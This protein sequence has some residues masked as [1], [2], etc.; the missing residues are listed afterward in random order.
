ML[1][2][3]LFAFIAAIGNALFVFGQRKSL[4]SPSPFLFLMVSLAIALL[5]LAVVS[6]FFPKPDL[7]RFLQENTPWAL[8]SGIGI[9]I[10]YVGFYYLY[11]RFGATYYILYAILAFITTSV[12]V[13]I[14]LLKENFN[15]YY[16]LSIV[17]A[18][19]TLFLFFLGKQQSS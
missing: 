15:L 6:I 10:T 18:A 9:A 14:V 12:I 13:G 16:L 4:V 7:P 19:L 17:C 11:N 5:S 8:L 2:A 1:S 3:F